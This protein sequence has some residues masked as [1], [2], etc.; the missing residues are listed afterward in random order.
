MQ[1]DRFVKR[2]MQKKYG[3]GVSQEYFS[4][5]TSCLV[6]WPIRGGEVPNYRM[7]IVISLKTDYNPLSTQLLKRIGRD[8]NGHSHEHVNFYYAL[9]SKKIVTNMIKPFAEAQP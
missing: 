7:G 8:A 5:T 4:A 1:F 2:A 6:L 3:K 9:S